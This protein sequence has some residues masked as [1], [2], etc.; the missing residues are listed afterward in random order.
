MLRESVGY[1]SAPGSHS[2]QLSFD[3]LV[4]ILQVVVY[5]GTVLCLFFLTVNPIYLFKVVFL[6]G[7]V[8]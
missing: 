3:C 2:L 7:G 6:H 1:L 5:M 4:V 8:C